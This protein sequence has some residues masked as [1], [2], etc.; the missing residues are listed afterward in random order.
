MKWA[1]KEEYADYLFDLVKEGDVE[2][3]RRDLWP[4]VFQDDKPYEQPEPWRY[5]WNCGD[6]QDIL[7]EACRI[8]NVPAFVIQRLL[9]SNVDVYRTV[10][11]NRCGFLTTLAPQVAAK[12]SNNEALRVLIDSGHWKGRHPVEYAN[13]AM[14]AWDAG[15][16]EG[17]R[18][19]MSQPR[20]A[21]RMHIFAMIRE[22]KSEEMK[23]VLREFLP[24]INPPPPR[25]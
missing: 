2:T 22:S 8:P 19:L 13:A 10:E 12:H 25:P 15:N 20:V 21:D 9:D 18:M 4:G 5:V 16:V 7:L 23:D 1:S 3:L 24:A 6:R 14:Q 17:V 11:H